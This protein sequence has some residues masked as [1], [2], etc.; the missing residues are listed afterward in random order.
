MSRRKLRVLLQ[1]LVVLI[2]LVFWARVVW[3]NWDQV[4]AFQWRISWLALSLSMVMLVLQ[5]VLLATIWW[6]ILWVMGERLPWWQGIALWLQ[7]Q[8]A[9]Y[10]PGGV[11]DVAARV[12]IGRQIGVSGRRMSA[13]VSLEMGLQV[14]SASVFLILA[15]ALRLERPPTAYVVLA[16]LAVLGSLVALIPPVFTRLLNLGL[17]LL[18]Q[19]PLTLQLTY[20]TILAFFGARL[21]GHFLLGAGFVLFVSGLGAVSWSA[22][23]L[24]ASAYVGAW[25][26]GFLAVFVPTGIGV[27][28]GALVVLLGS[29]FPFAAISTIALGYRIAIALRDLLVAFFGNWLS[30]RPS[31]A[32]S[33]DRPERVGLAE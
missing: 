29:Q 21:V 30:R 9:R 14:L 1:L 28:E 10:L 17:R 18:R 8:L 32:R 31:R 6:R 22:A 7:A 24:V 12:V 23:P 16:A 5:A 25:L 15:L 33:G 20:R 19:P 3:R 13:S 11:W 27:R 26:I 4:A 2:I